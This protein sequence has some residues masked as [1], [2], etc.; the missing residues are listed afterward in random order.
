MD[1]AMLP[2]WMEAILDQLPA[3][4]HLEQGFSTVSLLAFGA[5]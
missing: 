2:P 1:R 4:Q 5:R 3:S